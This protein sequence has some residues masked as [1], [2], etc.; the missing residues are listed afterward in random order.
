MSQQTLSTPVIQRTEAP[1]HRRGLAL[2]IIV[3]CQLML[4]LDATVMNVALPRIQTGLHFSATSLAWVMSAY[5]LAYGGLLLLGGRAGDILGRRRMF[6]AGIALFTVASLAGGFATSAGWL[7]AAR[8]AQGVGAAAA[9]PSTIA[10]IATTFTEPRE[11]IRALALLSGVASG[12]FAIGLVL[13]GILTELAS[14]RWVLF[15][16]VPFGLAAVLLAPRYVREPERHP[17][18]LD[19]PGAVAGTGAVATLVYTFIH[20]ASG[21]WSSRETQLTLA[22]GVVLLIAFLAIEIRTREPIMPLRLFADRNRAA[23]YLNFL[24]G[25]AAMMS[26]FFFLTQFLQE[27]RGFGAL[28]T[29]F[30]FMPMAAGMFIMTRLVPHLLHRLGPKPLVITGTLVMISGLIW[31]T[32]LSTSSGYAGAILGPMVLM[33]VGG[34]LSFVPLTPVIMASVAPKDAGAAGGV[35]QTM[36]QTGSSLGLAVL[37]TVFGSAARHAAIGAPAGVAG[38]H[39]TLVAGMT[40]AFTAA[41]V[42]A[43]G[44][45]VV[46]L[47]FRGSRSRQGEPAAG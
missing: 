5:T 40:S 35:L 17:A 9:G 44:T 30:A 3:T 21:G 47:T 24:L 32:Q 43:V 26:M 37:V 42:I 27:V 14:W 25:P 8:V 10:L 29:G 4:I 7:L 6:V 41:A 33:G 46:A 36:Q 12:G 20:A 28:A 18:R 19:L 31:L 15:I 22:A 16:N 34:G 23:A 2:A 45:V 39:H 13:G 38:A 1:P 11:R